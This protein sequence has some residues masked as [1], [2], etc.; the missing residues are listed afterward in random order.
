MTSSDTKNQPMQGFVVSRHWRSEPQGQRLRYWVKTSQGVLP[1][2]VTGERPVCFVRQ[3]Q[4]PQIQ[5]LLR[6]QPFELKPL[7]LRNFADEPV[8]A[9][10]APDWSRLRKWVRRLAQNGIASWEEDINPADRFLMERFITA[11]IQWHPSQ[12]GL[13]KPVDYQPELCVC[14]IDIE[15][16]FYI[17]GQ[18]PELYSIA[19]TTGEQGWVGVVTEHP[20]PA[21]HQ[22]AV[23][24]RF[25]NTRALLLAFIEQIQR[26]DP[27]VL[28]GWNVINF[29]LRILQMQC[30]SVEIPFEIGRLN[31]CPRWRE[32]NNDRDDWRLEL[33]GRMVLD[34][35]ESLRTAFY[36]FDS[37]A[38]DDVAAQVLGR[39]KLLKQTDEVKAGNRVQEITDMYLHNPTQLVS[40]NLEDCRLVLDIFSELKLLEFLIARS[41]LTGHSLDRLVGSA[42][43]FNYLY[44]P[45]LHRKGYVAPS[46]G[47]QTLRFHS[48]GGFVMNSKPGLY[49]NVLVLDFKSLYP[50]IIQT[51]YVDPYGMIRA[52]NGYSDDPL[53]G[54]D[55][56]VFDRQDHILPA[57]IKD[58]WQERDRAKRDNNQPLSQAIKII[59][60]SFYGV[61]GSDL[62]RFYD[63]RLSSSIT[64]RDHQIL[65]QSQQWIEQQGYQVIYGDTDS[66]FVW[67]EKSVD[68]DQAQAIG[69]KLMGGLNQWWT[70]YL[71]TE[72]QVPSHLEIEFETHYEKFLMPTIRGAEQGSKKRYAG[73]IRHQDGSS[74]MV[75]KGLETV[76]SDWTE[77]AKVFQQ[78]LYRRIFENED[79]VGYINQFVAELY[80]GERDDQLIYRRRLRKPLSEYQKN[81]PPHAQAGK[82]LQEKYP[83]RKIQ[84]VEYRM[85]VNGVEPLELEQSP[86]DYDFYLERQLEPIADTILYFL[87]QQFSQ[88]ISR[89]ITLL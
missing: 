76:R 73:L 67:I 28:L 29:D 50:S 72:Y 2:E 43:A 7:Q 85:T 36:H 15:T 5:A 61:L 54:F 33:E 24:V 57:L 35:I 84:R 4:I 19:M 9:L 45:R 71:M 66:L 1:L 14:S 82:L 30:D 88:V 38:L 58:L 46:V 16:S 34:G 56:G 18:L 44:L 26:L 52:L 40:Y 23:V 8:A 47:S 83:D 41:Y 78:E 75:F 13:Y 70:D 17:P 60:N 32:K 62:R 3:N 22:E 80:N 68:E 79:Y 81:I 63:P 65:K 39:G 49:Q 89:Q 55:G 37:Y 87:G 53:E 20:L 77:L 12:P 74:N 25:E 59:M 6:Q 11:G 69:R 51:F 42:A 48:P 86:L 27:D 31:E 21:Q 64:R 10:Y